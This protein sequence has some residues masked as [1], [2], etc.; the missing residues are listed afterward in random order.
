MEKPPIETGQTVYEP[1]DDPSAPFWAHG[2]YVGPYWSN[3]KVQSSVEFGDEAPTDALDE[4]A[5]LHD[6]AYAHWKD[7]AH[8]EAAD[9]L[10]ADAARRLKQKYGTTLASDPKF[11]ANAV[12]YGNYA[13]RSAKK[14]MKDSTQF[15]AL[16][17]FGVP[18]GLA[19]FVVQGMLAN[20]A[21]I[22]GTHLAREKAEILRY[23]GT[24]LGPNV[25]GG[26]SVLETHAKP[27]QQPPRRNDTPGNQAT[28][29]KS[30]KEAILTNL[31]TAARVKIRKSKKNKKRRAKV[32][33]PARQKNKTQKKRLISKNRKK[34]VM[35]VK[36]S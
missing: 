3:G 35:H 5:R 19:K 32:G 7:E 20:Q 25:T 4:L 27:T 15:A 30:Q 29:Q 2:K 23:F 13:M 1:G 26:T 6:T 34:P 22:R 14:L 18:L 8:R 11:A 36:S 17:P 24:R 31:E 9:A 28:P 16:G 12:E 21:R 33:T 10:F